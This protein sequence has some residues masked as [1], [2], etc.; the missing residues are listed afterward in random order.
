MVEAEGGWTCR[1]HL[2]RLLVERGV[3]PPLLL[4]E[5]GV[6][7]LGHERPQPV[8][9]VEV[10]QEPQRRVHHVDPHLAGGVLPLAAAV[11]VLEDGGPVSVVLVG[12][13]DVA[14][15]AAGEGDVVAVGELLHQRRRHLLPLPVEHVERQRWPPLELH[16]RPVHPHQR[17]P[18]LRLRVPQ[19]L[20]RHHQPVADAPQPVA[21]GDQ[22][23]RVRVVQPPA[24]HLHYWRWWWRRIGLADLRRVAVLL[25]CGVHLRYVLECERDEGATE[26]AGEGAGG[27]EVVRRR[28]GR[29]ELG[30]VAVV[31]R[32]A[33]CG[34][35]AD[36]ADAAG[37]DGALERGEAGL[38]DEEAREAGGVLAEHLEEVADDEVRAEEGEAQ[39]VEVLGAQ[40]A[41]VERDV[42]P[43]LVRRAHPQVWVPGPGHP[44]HQREHEEPPPVPAAAAAPPPAEQLLAEVGGVDAHARPRERRR[45]H[46]RT[47]AARALRHRAR[48]LALV[49]VHGE[50]P[51][52]V[53]L[54][55]V[56][57][58]QQPERGGPVRRAHHGVLVVGDVERRH[59]APRH[60]AADPARRGRRR[61]V[62][63]A[64]HLRPQA[65]GL[66]RD[67]K[68]RRL[69]RRTRRRRRRRGR[70]RRHRRV[71]L[72]V[73]EEVDAGVVEAHVAVEVLVLAVP[74][75]VGL[76]EPGVLRERGDE[77]GVRLLHRRERLVVGELRAGEQPRRRRLDEIV[78]RR[79]RRGRRRRRRRGSPLDAHRHA[80]G[81]AH[82]LTLRSVRRRWRRRRWHLLV[83]AGCRVLAPGQVLVDE[84]EHGCLMDRVVLDELGELQLLLLLSRRERPDGRRVAACDCFSLVAGRRRRRL[85]VFFSGYLFLLG[86]WW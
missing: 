51:L 79:P 50:Q 12:E 39:R 60:G 49:V 86:S 3:P 44:R 55:G 11:D 23:Q 25:A 61:D 26:W 38:L 80:A 46:L 74:D 6:Q 35:D 53:L 13:A 42:P 69:P 75:G 82:E 58:R 30:G 70:R 48:R 59:D 14:E 83:V 62:V 56:G 54:E 5:I 78:P 27:V 16:P 17:L 15:E 73:G 68:E 33:A 7:E 29:V 37:D 57:L 34:D 8:G 41:R 22:P 24:L 47:A 76:G 66:V 19:L 9:V 20:H 2:H 63:P 84:Q 71:H 32:P 65:R 1:L 45:H 28:G 85:L 72:R 40:R 64:L 67:V 81:D 4:H 43:L 52:A 36:D 10:G 21:Y 77:L 31:E 18:L